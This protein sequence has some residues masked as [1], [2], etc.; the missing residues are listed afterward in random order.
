MNVLVA[1]ARSSHHPPP[2]ETNMDIDQQKEQMKRELSEKLAEVSPN[3]QGKPPEDQR[4]SA[5]S[6]PASLWAPFVS[7]LVDHIYELV[8]QMIEDQQNKKR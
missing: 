1:K 5:F 2:K 3:V 6:L 4:F 7:M 8:R